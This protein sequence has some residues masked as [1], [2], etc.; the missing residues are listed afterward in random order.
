MGGNADSSE[1]AISNDGRYVD[2]ASSASN[3]VS[4]VPGH[5]AGRIAIDLDARGQFEFDER[6]G[7]P[8]PA[9]GAGLALPPAPGRFQVFASVSDNLVAGDTN[10]A[11][12]VFVRDT[13]TGHVV[14]ISVSDDGQQGNGASF[15][16]VLSGNQF[17]AAFTSSAS[18]LLAGDTNG[19]SDVF[20]ID[21]VKAGI[22]DD[23]S[24][25]WTGTGSLGQ[26]RMI[27]TSGQ[28]AFKGLTGADALY[29]FAGADDLRGQAGDDLL[30]GGEGNDRLDG[31]EGADLLYGGSGDDVL[32]GG[33]GADRMYGGRGADTYYVDVADD[34]VDESASLASQFPELAGDG[35]IDTI[36]STASW[37]MDFAGTAEILISDRDPFGGPATLGTRSANGARIVGHDGA[38]I[39]WG[40]TGAD[41]LIG[42]KGRDILFGLDGSDMLDGGDG[43]DV[44]NGGDGDDSLDGGAGTDDLYAGAGNDQ[45]RGGSGADFMYGGAGDDT[46][47]VDNALDF[48]DEGPVSAAFG[49]GSGGYDKVIVEA[50]WYWLRATGIEEIEMR[51]PQGSGDG[52]TTVIAAGDDNIIRGDAGRNYIFAG[53]GGDRVDAGA[54]I[55]DIFL[56]IGYDASGMV[57]GSGADTFVFKPGNAIDIVHDFQPGIDRIDLT[58]WRGSG[59]SSFEALLAT[60]S[61]IEGD[62]LVFR[63]GDTGADQIWLRGVTASSLTG[64]DILF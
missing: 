38:D 54:G 46:Y 34:V 4:D 43:N 31:G 45:L 35:A 51:R 60:S 58:A 14:R 12:D 25:V 59:P 44:L 30:D 24:V 9:P 29:G 33:A 23:G 36:R 15:S 57:S 28:D 63:F 10:G 18:N 16:P 21:L 1:G 7:S 22:I 13:L 48:I 26:D 64:A 2:F 56:D 47:W 6:P 20:A 39:L 62:T 42:G 53:A 19:V 5:P 49:L 11:S 3:L 61:V 32:I 55:D 17:V 40:W 8:Y 37:F 50:A 41:T 27:G 52:I